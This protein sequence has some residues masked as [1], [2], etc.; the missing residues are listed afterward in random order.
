MKPLYYFNIVANA[1]ATERGPSGVVIQTISLALNAL[2]GTA[3]HNN[4]QFACA[5]PHATMGEHPHPGGVLRVFTE[6]RDSADLF[7]EAI[8]S[9]KLLS[10]YVL[11]VGRIKPVPAGTKKSVTYAR[12]RLTSRSSHYPEHRFKRIRLGAELPHIQV[13]SKSTG[14][15]F[16]L[17]FE[18]KRSNY[19]PSIDIHPD[20][21]GL[22]VR[23]R[24]FRLPDIEEKLLPW[25]MQSS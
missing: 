9:H 19:E 15:I 21:F 14:Q 10:S 17:R 6:D 1:D 12:Y 22:S 25:R 8:E 20:S 13:F 18:L 4:V 7:A 24:E 5:F 16:S 2:H 23:E 3:R 11:P